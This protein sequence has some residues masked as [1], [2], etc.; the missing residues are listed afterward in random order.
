[1]GER[2][3]GRVQFKDRGG[4]QSRLKDSASW[5]L[6]MLAGTLRDARPPP[7]GR[8]GLQESAVTCMVSDG[9]FWNLWPRLEPLYN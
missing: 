6:V 4:R 9:N 2:M 7:S 5:P 3:D 8:S 1:M